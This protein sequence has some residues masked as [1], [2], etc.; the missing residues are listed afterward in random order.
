MKILKFKRE[1]FIYEEFGIY[2]DEKISPIKDIF[3][4]S[5]LFASINN[6]TVVTS[7]ENIDLKK[8]KILPPTDITSGAYCAGLNYMD[9]AKEMKMSPPA[10]PIF[11]YKSAGSICGA[12][13][14]II[15]PKITKLLDYEIEL[16]LIVGR[17][18]GPDDLIT[19]ENLRDY[20]LGVTILNDV[21]AR[22]VQLQSG[23]WFMGKNFST[24]APLGPI[25]LTLDELPED[26]LNNL[27]LKLQVYDKNNEPYENK[28]QRGSTSQMIFEPYK[29]IATLASQF[30]LYPGD[31]ISTGTPRGVALARPGKLKTRI[32]EIF[33]IS[34]GKRI[35]SFIKSEIKNN[36]KYLQDGDT[37]VAKIFE[38]DNDVDFWEQRNLVVKS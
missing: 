26:T 8:I 19:K 3:K 23:Q 32:A 30:N 25:V 35:S 33:G 34:P 18:I 14:N 28:K 11:F 24:A 12:F 31:V 21:S 10:R 9:H 7:D 15:Y 2:K 29:L 4:V 16:A 37:I 38:D 22:D 5:E 36:D 13:D 20:V 27:T 1:D 6:N 17:K